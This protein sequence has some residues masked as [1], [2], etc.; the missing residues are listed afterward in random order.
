MART[1]LIRAR[2]FCWTAVPLALWSISAIVGTPH[3]IWSYEYAGQ[4]YVDAGARFHTS[5]TYIGV[6]GSFRKNPA[7][8]RC[9]VIAFEKARP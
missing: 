9:P 8:G 2:Y 7:D 3:V 4:R 1:P 6:S 5:C